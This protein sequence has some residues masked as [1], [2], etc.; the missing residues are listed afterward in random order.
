[1][2]KG[3]LYEKNSSN[4]KEVEFEINENSYC[5][6]LNE[7]E[8]YNGNI[9]L[10][11]ISS[12]IGNTLRN[13]TLENGCNFTTFEN[14]LVDKHILKKEAVLFKLESNIYLIII[15]II[16]TIMLSLS[17]F[18]WGIPYSSKKVAFMLPTNFY[19]TISIEALDT[20]DK[21]AFKK[22]KLS[23]KKQKNIKNIFYQKILPKIENSD[24]KLKI[25]FREWKSLNKE[26]ANALALPNGD[27][28]LTDELIKQSKNDS[29]IKAVILHEIG[30]II[31][32]H[33]MQKIVE[34]SLLTI[35]LMY[36]S[37]D[38]TAISDLG[39]GLSS[40]LINTHYS[41]NHETQ[42]DEYALKKMLKLKIEPTNLSRLLTRITN[43]KTRE[44]SFID[45]FSSHPRTEQRKELVKKYQNCFDKKQTVCK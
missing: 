35:L 42:A 40:F 45:N 30:H 7:N 28:V 17:F 23:L 8:L 20:L 1:M 25:H 12:R 9:N 15:S 3:K 36:L 16:F 18:K 14:D 33:S 11:D 43:E 27:I 21:Y 37:G 24:F 6:K 10:L 4:S 34:N 13:I 44:K 39:V 26:I 29:E 22:S 2:I 32:R 38:A 41:R 31:N 19:S 5:I